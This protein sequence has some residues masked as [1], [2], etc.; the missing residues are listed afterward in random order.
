MQCPTNASA[1]PSTIL[2]NTTVSTWVSDTSQAGYSYHAD[3][4]HP[5][6]TA[7]MPATVIFSPAD[8]ISGNYAPVCQTGAGYVRIFSKVN[9]SITIPTVKVEG[10]LNYYATGS[11]IGS[12]TKPIKIVNGQAVAVTNA[13]V[14][15]NASITGATKCKITYDSKGL[16][17]SGANLAASDIPNLAWSKITSGKPTTIAGYGITDGAYGVK[18][19]TYGNQGAFGYG[20]VLGGTAHIWAS[21]NIHPSVTSISF[22]GNIW[23]RDTGGAVESAVFSATF[24]RTALGQWN[25]AT[26]ISGVSGTWV[27]T[28]FQLHGTF[29]LS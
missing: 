14:V 10:T 13:L 5:N 9:T 29:T 7:D 2:T 18:A 20:L 21:W 27:N 16:V 12:D 11:T 19:G 24:G 26:N 25:T 3:I 1:R 23:A 17:T 6:I 28:I 4:T 8:S 15:A 22:S